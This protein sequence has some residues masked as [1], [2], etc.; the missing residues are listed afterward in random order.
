VK[1]RGAIIEFIDV[2]FFNHSADDFLA[3]VIGYLLNTI[4]SVQALWMASAFSI[5]PLS[6]LFTL[7]AHMGGVGFS[8]FMLGRWIRSFFREIKL[9][10]Q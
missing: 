2:D 10:K 5:L 6:R 1:K 9:E 8:C 4:V 3:A 7:S